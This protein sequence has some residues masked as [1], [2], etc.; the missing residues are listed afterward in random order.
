LLNALHQLG[1]NDKH[2]RFYKANVLLGVATL[3]DIAKLARL[4]RSTAYVLVKELIVL[5]L[6]TEDHKT[7]NKR[8]IATS[9]EEILRMLE[10]KHRT[11]GRNN[12]AF[13]AAMPELRAAHQTVSRP[14]VRVFEGKAGLAAVWQ[15]IL[16][17]QQEVLLWTNQDAER[18]I[19]DSDTHRTFIKERVAKG[20]SMRVLGVANDSGAA[21]IKTD[22]ASLRQT[23]LLPTRCV[24]TSET[25]VYGNKVAVLDVAHEVFG[26]ITENEQ[27]AASQRALFEL[28]WTE[29]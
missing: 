14:R 28:A 23:K 9:P 8:F 1:C 15:D 16:R 20:I 22:V 25:Y 3:N 4:Q 21:L 26:V 24:F 18:A 27:I 7:Y 5:G 17:D 2:V 29:A 19:F 6:I 13:K 10:A 12:L 11:L